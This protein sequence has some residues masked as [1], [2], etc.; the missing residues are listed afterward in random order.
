MCQNSANDTS[1]FSKVLVINKSFTEPNTDLEKISQWVYQWKMQFYPD[2]EN[3]Q[4][5]SFSPVNYF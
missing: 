5:E 3:K 1:L 4:M 2:P